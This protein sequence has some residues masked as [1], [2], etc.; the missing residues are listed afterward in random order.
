MKEELEGWDNAH[1]IHQEL[2]GECNNFANLQS[3]ISSALKVGLQI[4]IFFYYCDSEEDQDAKTW[5]QGEI[6]VISNR[7]NLPKEGGRFYKR[8]IV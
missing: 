6:K 1:R 5:S 2:S 8:V 3:P 7:K 4:G